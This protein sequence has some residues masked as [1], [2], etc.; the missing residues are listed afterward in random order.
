MTSPRGISRREL[1]ASSLG[2][3]AMSLL[4]HSR[5][6]SADAPVDPNRFI[7][8]SD[9]H[10]S[11]HRHKVHRDVNAYDHFCEA[12]QQY[13][14]VNARPSRLILTGDCVFRTGELGDYRRLKEL[15]E[16]IPFPMTFA[17]GNHDLREHFWSVFPEYKAD[18]LPVAGRHITR[19]ESPLA[20]WFVLDSLDQNDHTPGRMGEAQL[21]W[22]AAELDRP[23]DKPAI[24]VAHHYPISKDD[25]STAS[26]A[27][28]DTDALYDV[29]LPRKRVKAYIF[30]H[31]H[32]WQHS[33]IDDLHL[34]NIAAVSWVFDPTQP[35]GWVDAQLRPDGIRVT[36]Q[37]IDAAHAGHNQTLDFAW[38]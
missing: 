24:V 11:E 2:A 18:P 23:S 19:F 6:W 15:V 7:I 16:P 12:R 35:Q 20:D 1:L 3:G 10:V 21:K 9:T 36:L 31:S 28:Q 33:R 37:C 4:L 14:A 32:R 13:L 30:G 38:R 22:L 27:L 29:I 5:L 25:P 34:I 8:L 17:M 26:G